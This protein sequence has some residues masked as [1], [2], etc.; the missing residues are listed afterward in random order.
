VCNASQYCP[1]RT[2]TLELCDAG[3]V[4]ATPIDREQCP[5]GRYCDAG[6]FVAPMC[7]GG[8][9]C[10]AGSTSSTYVE[11]AAGA[12]CPEGSFDETQCPLGSYCGAGSAAP[13][14]CASGEHCLA[15]IGAPVGVDDLQ[16]HR[17]LHRTRRCFFI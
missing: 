7:P 17:H 2:A 9:Y 1:V 6:T 5:A 16:K 4:C 14:A 13:T 8:K 15:G 3:F 12:F 11:C 10:V